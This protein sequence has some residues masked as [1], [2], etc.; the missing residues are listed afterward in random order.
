MRD[1]RR[2]RDRNP[3]GRSRQGSVARAAIEPGRRDGGEAPQVP[4]HDRIHAMSQRSRHRAEK[5]SGPRARPLT[6][7]ER[8][9][10]YESMTDAELGRRT[11][12]RNVA[13][14]WDTFC[15]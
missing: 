10:L 15:Q 8:E 6:E 13:A 2:A 9:A 12:E 14:L 7:D 4:G 3:H 1:C 5:D 11:N